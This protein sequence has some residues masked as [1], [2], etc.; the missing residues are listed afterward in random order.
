MDASHTVLR[1]ELQLDRLHQ[2]I[3][4]TREAHL[5]MLTSHHMVV[6]Q[7]WHEASNIKFKPCH[8]LKAAP[9]ATIEATAEPPP[10]TGN[11]IKQHRLRMPQ[12]QA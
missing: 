2:D 3:R 5:H 11:K 12:M 8:L 7:S 6:M 9:T 4:P 10:P 1:S